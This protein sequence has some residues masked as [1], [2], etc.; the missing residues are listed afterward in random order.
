MFCADGVFQLHGVIKRSQLLLLLK[1]RIGL[2]RHDTSRSHFPP[3]KTHIPGTQVC[4]VATWLTH[5]L[6]I[7]VHEGTLFSR[8]ST[9]MPLVVA[10][11]DTPALKDPCLLYLAHSTYGNT[12]MLSK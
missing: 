12:V 10:I 6:C 1:H 7:Y 8:G 2:Y 9:G 5:Y 11:R 3:S 4:F